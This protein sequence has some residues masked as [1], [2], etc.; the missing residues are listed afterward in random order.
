MKLS[1]YSQTPY[2]PLSQQLSQ[3]S[4]QTGDNL[5]SSAF[6]RKTDDLSREKTKKAQQMR[7]LLRNLKKNTKQ[8]DTDEPKTFIAT[9]KDKE[10][11]FLK[12]SGASDQK[13]DKTKK[14]YTYNSREIATKIQRAKTSSGAGLALIAAKRKVLEVKRKISA[15]DGDAEELQLAL[16]HARR[17]E[18]VARKKK[19]HLELE[20]M[21]QTTGER[22]E[23]LKQQEEAVSDMK[24][25]MIAAEEEKIM[26]QEDAIFE[27]RDVQISEAVEE[28]KESGQEISDEML[29]DLNAMI[30]EFGE[31][32]LEEL[33]EAMEMLESMEIIDP[34]M[35]KEDLEE[36]K[37]KH[38]ASEQKEMV[39]ADMDYLKGM[40]KHQVKMGGAIPGISSGA[41]AM[42]AGAGL[43][44]PSAPMSIAEGTAIDVQL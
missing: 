23:R 26:E 20:E 16:T 37:R 5:L 24:N 28:F 41:A 33:E 40:I 42:P 35:S 43:T 11:G 3:R 34:H 31:D 17:M 19:H 38:R 6:S 9:S 25:A 29:A 2:T 27:E 15:G 12:L 10:D 36:L 21:A 44:I 13:D 22:D 30:S 4:N 18:M 39:K 32:M 7:E 1:G 14:R 8:E